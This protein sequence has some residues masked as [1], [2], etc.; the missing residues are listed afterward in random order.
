MSAAKPSLGVQRE[1]EI[2][3]ICISLMDSDRAILFSIFWLL[4]P[5]AWILQILIMHLLKFLQTCGK[6]TFPSYQLAHM[7]LLPSNVKKSQMVYK[8]G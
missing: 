7:W 6:F 1:E 4:Q 8:V 2:E 5:L 3:Q